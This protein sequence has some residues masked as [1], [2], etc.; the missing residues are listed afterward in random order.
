MRRDVVA[1]GPLCPGGVVAGRWRREEALAAR[2][3]GQPR[4]EQSC[5]YG[6]LKIDEHVVVKIHLRNKQ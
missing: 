5:R 6:T 4:E 2:R 3:G 1:V